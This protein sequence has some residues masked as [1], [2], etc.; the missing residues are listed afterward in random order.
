MFNQ[1]MMYSVIVIKGREVVYNWMIFKF[2]SGVD[3]L[4]LPFFWEKLID[5]YIQVWNWKFFIFL[6]LLRISFSVG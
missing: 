2:L 5:I 3:E 1:Q 4:S 6:L